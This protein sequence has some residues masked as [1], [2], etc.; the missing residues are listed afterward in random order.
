MRKTITLTLILFIFAFFAKAQIGDYKSHT[1][2]IYN[3]TKYIQWP[4]TYQSGDFVIAVYGLSPLTA[5]LRAATSNKRVGNQKIV[6]KQYLSLNAIEN[7]HILFISLQQS[8][9][10]EAIKKKLEGKSTLIVT[11]KPGLGP[12][13]H[14]NFILREGKWKIELNNATVEAAGLKVSAQL[15]R[16]AIPVR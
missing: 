3:F 12:Q 16:I 6:V 4:A 14:I 10:L 2:Y 5:Q 8:K 15:S 1:V 13:S 7:P 9:N 11:E